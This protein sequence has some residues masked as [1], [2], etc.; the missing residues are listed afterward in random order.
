MG[1]FGKKKKYERSGG[2]FAYQ[3]TGV[4][5]ATMAKPGFADLVA[6]AFALQELTG[7]ANGV[8]EKLPEMPS[9]LDDWGARACFT[10]HNIG[11]PNPNQSG[12]VAKA[13]GELVQ[14]TT[15]AAKRRDQ[16]AYDELANDLLVGTCSAMV[17]LLETHS[18]LWGPFRTYCANTWRR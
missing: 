16:S 13:V 2:D 1:L 7:N 5:G 9:N 12:S 10:D 6:C 4:D 14:Q 18:D 11:V 17:S 8:I 15:D 3:A